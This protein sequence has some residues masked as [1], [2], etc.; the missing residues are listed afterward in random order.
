MSRM[1]PTSSLQLL[2]L[3]AGEALQAHLED[4][5]RLL[6]AEARALV[7]ALQ[8]R[9]GGLARARLTSSSICALAFA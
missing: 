4:V 5:L 6:L 2:A 3:Q 9:V 8:A 7:L 1:R